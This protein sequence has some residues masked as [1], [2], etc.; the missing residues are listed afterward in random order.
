M[1]SEPRSSSSSQEFCMLAPH[2]IGSRI[3]GQCRS[4]IGCIRP[5]IRPPWSRAAQRQLHLSFTRQ[6]REQAPEAGEEDE[7]YA[8][9]EEEEPLEE[10]SEARHLI[11]TD[12][13]LPPDLALDLRGVFD[14]RFKDPRSIRPERFMWDYWHVPH[15]Y[16][17][18]RTQA[19]DYFPKPVYEALVGRFFV[20][21]FV[22]MAMTCVYDFVYESLVGR[23]VD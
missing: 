17:L 14:D 8:D 12:S 20:Y 9:E 6:A 23:F 13:F 21:D 1:V 4:I 22:S 2:R 11:I 19:Q 15:Q 10:L 5:R 7:L 3:G 16:T 18:I